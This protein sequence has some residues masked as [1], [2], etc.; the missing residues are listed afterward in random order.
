MADRHI[1]IANDFSKYP[2]GRTRRDGSFSAEKF[3][4][5]ILVPA[6]QAVAEQGDHVVVTLDGVYGYSSSFL[7]ETF[8][9]LVRR[10]LFDPVW[11]RR[12]LIIRAD[13][14]IYTSYKL[15]AEQYLADELAAA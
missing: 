4:D 6:L 14:P 13:D 15:D 11:L 2:A 1:S 5:D 3:R 10:R 7:E 8:G 12:C 9:G